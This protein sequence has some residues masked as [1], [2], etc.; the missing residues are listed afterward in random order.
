MAILTT[1]NTVVIT[2]LM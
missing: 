2:V 1:L